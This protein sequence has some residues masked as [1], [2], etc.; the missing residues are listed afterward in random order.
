M[1]G[2]STAVSQDAV[3]PDLSM[4]TISITGQPVVKRV[5]T[6]CCCYVANIIA[7]YMK[8]VFA[9]FETIRT[10][11]SLPGPTVLQFRPLD[12]ALQI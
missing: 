5:S 8:A 2:T 3:I 12:T 11:G 1:P 10:S 6:T 7:S 4:P 9:L